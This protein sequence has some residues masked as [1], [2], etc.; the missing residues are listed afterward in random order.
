MSKVYI[1]T[2]CDF[3]WPSIVKVFNDEEKAKVFCEEHNS[4]CKYE[5]QEWEYFDYEVF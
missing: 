1:V 2:T 4:S 3:E 5:F